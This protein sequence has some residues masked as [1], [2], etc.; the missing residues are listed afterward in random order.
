MEE[1]ARTRT[2]LARKA[3]ER[4]LT[5]EEMTGSTFTISNL[6]MFDIDQFQALIQPPEAAILAVGSIK[7]KPVVI[8]GQIVVRPMINLTLSI[9]H[10]VLDGVAGARFLQSLKGYI[11]HPSLLLL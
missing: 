7:D 4:Q 5:V 1:I 6:G 8:D 10:R 9:D 11:E 2:E 3:T